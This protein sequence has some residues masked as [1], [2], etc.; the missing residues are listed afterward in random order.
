[1]ATATAATAAAATGSCIVFALTLAARRLLDAST[2]AA[3]LRNLERAHAAAVARRRLDETTLVSSQ[4]AHARARKRAYERRDS[5][6]LRF[7]CRRRLG[8]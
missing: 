1:M 8:R 4:L 5:R 6:R 3:N 2:V 7:R